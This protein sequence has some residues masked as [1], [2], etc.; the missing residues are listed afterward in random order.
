[1]E[2]NGKGQFVKEASRTLTTVLEKHKEAE[3][4]YEDIKVHLTADNTFA[5]KIIGPDGRPLSFT[6]NGKKQLLSRLGISTMK[7]FYNKKLTPETKES[8]LK[9]MIKDFDKEVLLRIDDGK[10]RGVLSSKYSIIDHSSIIEQVNNVVGNDLVLEQVN[11]GESNGNL[12]VRMVEAGTTEL[13]TGFTFG[14]S[15]VGEGSVWVAPFIY[16]K[17]CTN[18]M[19]VAVKE[20]T[21]KHVHFGLKEY[22]MQDA[23]GQALEQTKISAELFKT[24]KKRHIDDPAIEIEVIGNRLHMTKKMIGKVKEAYDIEPMASGYGIINAITRAAQSED[25]ET[26]MTL[27]KMASGLLHVYN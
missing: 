2:R 11:Y 13:Q 24:T 9:D 12:N 26:R 19:I 8:I 17:V 23:I 18:G 16:R 3:K 20:V 25:L 1:M 7:F 14:N 22:S 6:E 4:K 27:E 15:E 10:I 5:D 21:F